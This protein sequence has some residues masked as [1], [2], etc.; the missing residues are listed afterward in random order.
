MHRDLIV[1]AF[2]DFVYVDLKLSSAIPAAIIS[3]VPILATP[4]LLSG[5]SFLRPPALILHPSGMS[6]ISAIGLLRQGVDPMSYLPGIPL[7]LPSTAPEPVDGMSIARDHALEAAEQRFHGHGLV[8][9]TIDG[10]WDRYHQTLYEAN[11]MMM[12][13]LLLDIEA[14][15]ETDAV[16][17][18]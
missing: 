18:S 1:P 3:G 4:L 13:R 7:L 9:R 2:R 8:L 10:Q 11:A 5:Y 17:E 14:R 6:E 12:R 15:R 16:N